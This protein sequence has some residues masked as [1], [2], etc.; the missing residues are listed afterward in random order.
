MKFE[1]QNEWQYQFCPIHTHV[2]FK[3][4]REKDDHMAT[5]RPTVTTRDRAI[6]DILTEAKKH[7]G[8]EIVLGKCLMRLSDPN[9]FALYLE[10]FGHAVGEREA[11]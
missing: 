5:H 6:Y 11:L 4:Q 10:T 2:A 7:G 3:N 1:T 8:G 9:L